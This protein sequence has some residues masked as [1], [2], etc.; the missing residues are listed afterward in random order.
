MRTGKKVDPE[1]VEDMSAFQTHMGYRLTH[2]DDGYAR[3]EQPL[4]ANLMNRIGIPHGGNYGV[5]LDT[6]MGFSG[7]YTGDPKRRLYALTLSI[8]VNFIAPARGE[9]LVAEAEVVGGSR[10]T[11]FAEGR[12]FDGEGR[13]IAQSTGTFQRRESAKL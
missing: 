7:V 5:I 1:L 11:F 3:L 12:V 4:S 2:W 6:A 8:T 13:V 10:Q 9:L